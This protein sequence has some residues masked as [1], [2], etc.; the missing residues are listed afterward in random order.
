MGRLIN[1]KKKKVV[2]KIPETSTL[3]QFFDA[4]STPKGVINPEKAARTTN[5]DE[6]SEI[7]EDWKNFFNKML[8]NHIEIYGN[9][10]VLDDDK[11]TIKL[12]DGHV[13]WE[14]N[15]CKNIWKDEDW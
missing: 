8:E 5:D 10:V 11:M 3:E 7:V 1:K 14:R 15:L 13:M 12:Q 9:K 6:R 4:A 2:H